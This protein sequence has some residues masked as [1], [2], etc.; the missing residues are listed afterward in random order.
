[1]RKP[2]L[3]AD[4]EKATDHYLKAAELGYSPAQTALALRFAGGKGIEKDMVQAY[5]WLVIAMERKDKFAEQAFGS[6]SSKLN[7]EQIAEGE[8]M[9]SE[10]KPRRAKS[11]VEPRKSR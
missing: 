2:C 5:K 7:E 9:A 10:F 8:A 3:E 11:W 6:V 1:M 4:E